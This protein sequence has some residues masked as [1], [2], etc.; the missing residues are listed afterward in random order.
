MVIRKKR[1]VYALVQ[2]IHTIELEFKI[3]FNFQSFFFHDHRRQRQLMI[4]TDARNFFSMSISE[5]VNIF[6][7]RVLMVMM[8]DQSRQI[9]ET[10]EKCTHRYMQM[11]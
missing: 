11:K 10:I 7:Q 5:T 9:C 2:S 3:L 4:F 6:N 1:T 8:N